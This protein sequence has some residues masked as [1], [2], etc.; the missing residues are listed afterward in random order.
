M[1][2]G[3]QHSV[4][5]DLFGFL[6]MTRDLLTEMFIHALIVI[7]LFSKFHKVLL[8]NVDFL[9]FLQLL[10]YSYTMQGGWKHSHSD[11]ST[12]LLF[13]LWWSLYV[14][15]F[16]ISFPSVTCIGIMWRMVC[17]SVFVCVC[18]YSHFLQV[19][20]GKL[21]TC[22]DAHIVC[23]PIDW[24]KVW[25]VSLHVTHVISKKMSK[26]IENHRFTVSFLQ[27]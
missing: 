18:V 24:Q 27:Q 11:I 10:L 19:W 8:L 1:K 16:F 21:Q 7:L 25:S 20:S 26:L 22:L 12:F 3:V 2:A 4:M 5:I 17:C 13:R 6:I 15:L 23:A 14:L 9:C